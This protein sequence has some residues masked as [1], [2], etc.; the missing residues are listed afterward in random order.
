M[1]KMAVIIVA[2]GSGKRFG[3]NE[4]KIF[5]KL[6]NQPLF[7][8]AV[9]LFVNRDDVS[10]TILVVAPSEL[11]QMKSKFGANLGFMG[12]KLVGGGAERHDS[13]ANGLA[14]V[15]DD[16]EFIAVHDA[17]R[18]CIAYEWI[19]TIFAAA[20]K[21]GAAVPVIPVTS[22]LK[23]MA[24][25]KTLSETVLRDGLFMAQTP[26]IFRADVL[27]AA[28]AGLDDIKLHEGKPITDDAQLV[29]ASG[30]P[31]TAVEGDSRNIKITT[32]GDLTLAGAILKCLPQKPI[33]RGGVFEE[34][35]W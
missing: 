2:A 18:V 15:N 23:R 29:S 35:R 20:I 6:D 13:V 26:Q 32:R 33:S 17:A 30:F 22:T 14:A 34:A 25:D 24:P 27:K 11:E 16:A 28:Y 3:G 10:Q 5:A 12:V 19:G 21:T 31:V 4:S 9:Q 7:L 8:R 1:S